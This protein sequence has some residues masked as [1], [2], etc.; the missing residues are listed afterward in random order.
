MFDIYKDKLA[1]TSKPAKLAKK[2]RGKKEKTVAGEGVEADAFD[3]QGTPAGPTTKKTQFG[4]EG[5]K[6]LVRKFKTAELGASERQS[7]NAFVTK[8]LVK[9][10]F[11]THPFASD[12]ERHVMED[13]FDEDSVSLSDVLHSAASL[14]CKRTFITC[15]SV[16]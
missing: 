15:I 2:K 1:P 13:D 14:V 6:S 9:K 7:L 16:W 10:P 4:D 11:R 12:L 3:V 8:N 5:V